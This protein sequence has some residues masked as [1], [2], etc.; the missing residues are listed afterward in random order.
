[1]CALPHNTRPSKHID[2]IL[3]YRPIR[4]NLRKWT[5]LNFVY[6][7]IITHYFRQLKHF[8]S[9]VFMSE[10]SRFQDIPRFPFPYKQGGPLGIGV[11]RVGENIYFTMVMPLQNTHFNMFQSWQYTS[12]S[13]IHCI[14]N[15]FPRH[16][17][18]WKICAVQ[19][20]ALQ[21]PSHRA[22]NTLIQMLF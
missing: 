3:K 1:M 8:S 21:Y 10:M 22:T 9:M 14:Y 20:T 12:Y 17:T 15:I 6:L 7:T 4:V 2:L 18:W 16:F 19:W 11:W 13:N 5:A